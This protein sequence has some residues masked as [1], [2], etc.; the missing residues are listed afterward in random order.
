MADYTLE[1]ANTLIVGMS[2][3]GKSTFAYRYLLNAPAA[4]RFLFDDLGRAATRL[5]LRPC[6]TSAELEAALASRWVIFNPARMFPD[7]DYKAAFR[8]FCDWVYAASQR[9]PGK[10]LVLV[11]EIWQWQDREDIPRE[12]DRLVRLG[13]EEDTELV[14]ATQSPSLINASITG[15][16]TELVCFRL[17]EP[18]EL[19]CVRRLGADA[20]AVQGLPLGSFL[21][22]NRLTRTKLSGKLF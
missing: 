14:S 10:K 9:G 8:F 2:G 7:G 22:W 20:E 12:L 17:D 21:S 18:K 1:L 15:Q 4:C 3:S 16:S 19:A 6:Y 5:N 13:R 11:D